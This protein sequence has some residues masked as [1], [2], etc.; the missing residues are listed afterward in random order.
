MKKN[1]INLLLLL[2][3]FAIILINIFRDSITEGYNG[4]NWD[5]S[6]KYK[7]EPY[8]GY[9]KYQLFENVSNQYIVEIWVLYINNQFSSLGSSGKNCPIYTYNNKPTCC[10]DICQNT[11]GTINDNIDGCEAVSYTHLTLPTTP[12]V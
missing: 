3:L 2:F 10:H 7:P 4:P 12:Y 1:K 8:D 9:D 6:T 5:E 11:N